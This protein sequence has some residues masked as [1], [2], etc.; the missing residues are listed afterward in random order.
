MTK[1]FA[2]SLQAFGFPSQ[3]SEYAF[4]CCREQLGRYGV[5]LSYTY[6]GGD[7]ALIV[8]VDCFRAVGVDFL[9][10][11]EYTSS[12]PSQFRSSLH[13]LGFSTSISSL[14]SYGTWYS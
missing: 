4:E 8:Y 12:I 14:H 1:I 6:P 13:H 11:F 2:I 9:Q 5:S 10:E 7:V 3:S